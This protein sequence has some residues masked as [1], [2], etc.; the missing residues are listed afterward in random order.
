MRQKL[1]MA[2]LE[3]IDNT[4]RQHE[5]QISTDIIQPIAPQDAHRLLPYGEMTRAIFEALKCAE[6]DSLSTTDLTIFIA[7]SIDREISDREF[8]TLKH[9]VGHRLDA[10]T[11]VR[12]TNRIKSIG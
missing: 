4:L 2:D 5:I 11:S 1:L 9:S 3:A 7:S 10:L 6:E 8:V 12:L